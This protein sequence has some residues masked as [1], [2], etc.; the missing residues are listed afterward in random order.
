MTIL[1]WLSWL[2]YGPE[3]ELMGDRSYAV[4]SAA[5]SR[6][7]TAGV[8]TVPALWAGKRTA[9]PEQMMRIDMLLG[10]FGSLRY[11]LADAALNESRI[12]TA[13]AK[14]IGQMAAHDPQ[15]AHY[16]FTLIDYSGGFWVTRS[17]GPWCIATPYQHGDYAGDICYCLLTARLKVHCTEA[18]MPK[19][20]GWVKTASW[21]DQ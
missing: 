9:N 14:L 19:E 16:L 8:L 1:M 2:V 13:Q 11:R 3:I 10:R 15:F 17:A 5:Y 7:K 12:T 4:R 20:I 18:P 21:F 6:L